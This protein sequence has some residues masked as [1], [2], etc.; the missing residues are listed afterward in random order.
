MAF[1]S[2]VRVRFD[3]KGWSG[4][5]GA[6]LFQ[7]FA[8][9]DLSRGIF[10]THVSDFSEDGSLGSPGPIISTQDPKD[11][12]IGVG[13]PA[14]Q[15]VSVV[16]LHHDLQGPLGGLGPFQDL[17]SPQ[18]PEVIVQSS[19]SGQFPL[20]RI[21]EGV[22]G[23]GIL[24]VVQCIPKGPFIVSM[25]G[26]G[27]HAPSGQ[28][29]E[30]VIIL[31]LPAHVESQFPPG[32]ELVQEGFGGISHAPPALSMSSGPRREPI[33]KPIFALHHGPENLV[34]GEVAEVEI[35][36]QSAGGIV[37][38]VIVALLIPVQ[39]RLDKGL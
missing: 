11:A 13:V 21:P 33:K 35:G 16:E 8:K 4:P 25:A 3:A 29:A 26:K 19:V 22:M 23:A 5:S 20:G 38:R 32:N 39:A 18:H 7:I 12:A 37:V 10:G 17:L 27:L 1:R 2:R 9:A 15:G 6:V 36:R 30:P 14:V 34:G 24:E 28:G 31:M